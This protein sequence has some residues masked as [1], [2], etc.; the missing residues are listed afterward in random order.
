[1][2][3]PRRSMGTGLQL[4][5][6]KP[7]KRQIVHRLARRDPGAIFQQFHQPIGPR[8]RRQRPGTVGVVDTGQQSSLG[9][10]LQPRPQPLAPA[11]PT[12]SLLPTAR[13][14]PD[15]TLWR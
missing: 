3:F 6:S 4:L 8:Q 9:V 1:M 11:S 5:H 2:A 13:E 15:N 14:S 10:G 7:A 12:I